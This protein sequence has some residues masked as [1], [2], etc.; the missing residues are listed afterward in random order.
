MLSPPALPARGDR[1]A[2]ARGGLALCRRGVRPRRGPAA[3]GHESAR[4]DKRVK[5]DDV[6]VALLL[7]LSRARMFLCRLYGHGACR[8][9]YACC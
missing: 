2:D 3:G 7:W 9:A 6:L 8:P 4:D 1:G 5:R